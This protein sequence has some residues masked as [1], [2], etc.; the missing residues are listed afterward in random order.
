M[1]EKTGTKNADRLVI[2]VDMDAFFAA[3]EQRDHEEYRGKPVIVGGLS[4]RGVVSTA[5]Y[6][7][8]RFGV[9]SAMPMATA[10]RR[11]PDGIF[12]PGD[13][14]R[15]REVSAQIFSILERF[16]PVLEPLSIDEGFLDLTGM[17]WLMGKARNGTRG[18][19]AATLRSYGARLKKAVFEETGL[20]AS[21]GIAPNKFLAKLASDLEK[22]DGLVVLSME[23][24]PNILWPLPV[25]RIWG[26]GKKTG[27]RLALFGYRRIADLA[28]ANP[29]KLSQQMGE[30]LAIHLI[31]LAKGEDDRPVEPAREV[32]SIG[33]ETT[34][35]RDLHTREEAEANLL[36]LAAQVGWRLRK[37]GK[38]A[39]TI[40]LKLRFGDFSTY[41]RQKTLPVATCYDED[42]YRTARELFRAFSMPPGKGIRLLGI[43]GSGFDA[44][45]ELSLFG[46]E[47]S[48]KKERLYR[49]VDGL[50]KRFGE[51]IVSH[52]GAAEN[53]TGGSS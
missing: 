14:R 25:S 12:L 46:M 45:S 4:P 24:V 53:Y 10:R 2:H 27:E 19:D 36:S 7:A 40:Q 35:E 34:F 16:S 47:S 8:R 15:Y 18:T 30:R 33:R 21:V 42:I 41:T 52:L 11:C 50:K 13:H 1:A 5:S 6:E 37:A 38:Q 22:P 32:Q 43:S 49:A 44:P 20:V 9:H 3:V 39:H 51:G 26:V 48:A 31:R 29:G 23:D 28:R 17:A